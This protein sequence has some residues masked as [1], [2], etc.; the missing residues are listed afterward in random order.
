MAD[1]WVS[2]EYEGTRFSLEVTERVFEGQSPFQRASVV[3]TR[4][5]GRALLIDDVFMTSERDEFLYHEMLVH[6]PLLTLGRP[7]ERVLIIGGGDGGTAREVLRH[8]SVQCV[9]MVEIDGTVVS[10]CKEHLPSIGT[11]WDDPRL[12]LRIDDGIKYV[13]ETSDAPYDAILLDGTDPVGPAKGL[14]N[15]SFYRDA[16][17]LLKPDG[18]FAAQ[19]E[20]PF[21]MPDVFRDIQRTLRKVF[22]RVRPYFGVVPI[23][24]AGYWSWTHAS[25]SLDPLAVDERAASVIEP[26]CRM[27]NR[28]VHRSAFAQPNFIRELLR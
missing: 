15:E 28:D 17:R 14:F 21:L 19:T 3:D 23:Y 9:V 2:E 5:F 4:A 11:A 27:Y 22:P 24:A 12:D 8:S 26:D 13:R 16:A 20:S 1:D 6:V 25:F 18:V 7:P 10:A